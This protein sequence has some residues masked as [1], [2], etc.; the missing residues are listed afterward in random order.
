MNQ[1]MYLRNATNYRQTNGRRNDSTQCHSGSDRWTR[2]YHV[3]INLSD[4]RA[5]TL[6]IVLPTMREIVSLMIGKT[7]VI[8]EWRFSHIDIILWIVSRQCFTPVR[9]LSRVFVRLRQRPLSFIHQ[10]WL[11]GF[12]ST[13]DTRISF[14]V[15]DGVHRIFNGARQQFQPGPRCNRSR[16]RFT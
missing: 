8:S 13:K 2:Y 4:N 5:H 15:H 16:R 3:R 6:P 14:C 12:P 11:T 9:W 7:G 1:S 10:R